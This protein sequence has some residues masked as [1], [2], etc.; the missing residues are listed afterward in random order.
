MVLR[1]EEPS[2]LR[3]FTDAIN[4]IVGNID[5]PRLL[6]DLS[7]VEFIN[8]QCLG[9]LIRL[10]T[11]LRA[12][13]GVLVLLNCRHSVRDV[14]EPLPRRQ[15]LNPKSCP[16]F[17]ANDQAEVLRWFDFVSSIAPGT[18]LEVDIFTHESP[19]VAS[20]EQLAWGA[21]GS[22]VR[23]KPLPQGLADVGIFD[24]GQV[25]VI[26]PNNA[27]IRDTRKRVGLQYMEI[28]REY[29]CRWLV[30][31]LTELQPFG[32]PFHD[33]LFA[34][35]RTANS[36]GGRIALCGVKPWYLDLLSIYPIKIH[37]CG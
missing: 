19:A 28:V 22:V 16:M 4:N 29:D 6:V 15:E 35:I 20:F 26:R 33:D 2:P 8:S 10:G 9:D 17:L 27:L 32:H 37:C 34:L 11:Q 1:I 13:G 14:M 31:N 30:V 5:P 36:L 21:G 25:S 18:D 3:L 12:K 7:S 23:S 24:I